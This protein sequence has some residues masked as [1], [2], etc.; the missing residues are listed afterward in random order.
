MNLLT[1]T[2]SYIRQRKLSTLLNVFLLALGIGTIVVLMLF[3]RQFEDNMLKN[4]KGIDL[5]V[6]AK[7]SPMQLILSSIYHLDV[8]TGNIPL[9]EAQQLMR[10]RM[11]K[12]AIPL[13]L[14]DSYRNYRIVGTNPAYLAHYEMTFAEGN[15]W[16]NTF[17]VVVGAK[18]AEEAGI[19]IG[20]EL[21]SSHGLGG[22]GDAHGD[23]PLK[24]KGI[25]ASA[26]NVVDRLVLTSV[27][28]VWAV[29]DEHLPGEDH[30]EDEHGHGEDDH[31]HDEEG[32]EEHEEERAPA[33]SE[34]DRQI[35]SL[36]LQYRSPMAAVMFPR[37]V[38][39]RTSMQSAA[40]AFETNRLFSMVGVGY[41]ALNTFGFILMF[42]AALSVFVALYN[43]L[44]DRKYDLAI[45]R[46]LG[47]SR[48]KLLWQILLEGLL[49]TAMGVIAGLIL[50]HTA[51]QML[52]NWFGQAQQLNM[53][54]WTWLPEEWW[55]I[56]AALLIGI[57]SAVIPAVQAYRTDISRTLA[58]A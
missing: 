57:I 22:E 9:Q 44:K 8:P 6:G 53:T 19:K 7:G 21:V 5:V 13:A 50:G 40:P 31:G 51:A 36:L 14:G 28:T 17:D 15:V 43:A 55:L 20:D 37:F 3:N 54:G 33:V 41:D 12:Q 2:L 11:I 4:A 38:N 30:D 56:G 34:A 1:L 49:L 27:E 26:G 52:G 46:S 48:S 58:Q 23:R 18:V 45:M 47:A 16:E 25:L 29:H 35:T 42:A 10:H 39:S 32:H 24:V